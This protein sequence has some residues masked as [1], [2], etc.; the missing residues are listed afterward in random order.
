MFPDSLIAL[1]RSIYG[2]G[3]IPLHRPVFEGNE[4]QY[5]IDCIDS[6][7]VSS[8]GAKVTEFEQQ[9]AKFTG[10]Q[11]AIATVNG[12]AALHVALDL[13][14]V[15][16]GDEVLTQAL[17]FIATC[18]AISH[19][20]AQPVFIDVD[21][22]TMGMGANA[23]RRFLI[24]HAEMRDGQAYN[25]GTGR[26][27]AACSP[28]HTFG[29]P[30]RIEEIVAI[31]S[32]YGIP[33][34]EDAAES[35]GSYVGERHTGTF[36]KL[37]TLSFNGNKVITTGGGGMIITDDEALA[38]RAKHL[39]TTAKVPHP[40]EFVHDEIGYNYRMPN[41]NAALGCAQM[42]ML[43]AMLAIKA[44]VAARYAAFF[45]GTGIQFVTPPEGSTSNYWLNA[46]VLGADVERDTF[47]EY[48]NSRDVMTRPIWRLMSGLEMFKHC[49]HDGLENSHWLEERVVN[50]PSSVPES[51][52]WRLNDG[53][54]RSSI[55]V[56]LA[57]V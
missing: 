25:K 18:N 26:R 8:V 50:L 21:R 19:A 15:E 34:V 36:G 32:E 53:R 56:G 35:L 3:F 49:Q 31:C 55:G 37:A 42:E 5:L 46:I 7:F 9:I 39:T 2:D 6:N 20:G 27:F 33:V 23:L 44:E 48:T 52:F 30:C 29:Q 57:N 4:K 24:E 54:S 16:R 17:T 43:P 12:T 28:M 38:K 11:Y 1:V 41:L 40:Y 51:E 14:G 47:L 22:D 45:A 10:A 13:V